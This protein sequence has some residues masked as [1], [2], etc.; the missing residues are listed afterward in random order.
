MM[1]PPGDFERIAKTVPP[2][3]ELCPGKHAYTFVRGLGLAHMDAYLKANES[4]AHFLAGDIE[5]AL[6]GRGVS[7]HVVGVPSP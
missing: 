2:I 4:A 5:A 7:V 6:A 3:T 1:P